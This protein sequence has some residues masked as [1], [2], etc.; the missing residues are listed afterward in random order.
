MTD[1]KKATLHKC[2]ALSSLGSVELRSATS[3]NMKCSHLHAQLVRL[4]KPN[5]ADI[6]NAHFR[7][8]LKSIVQRLE[9]N[10]IVTL[11]Q[12]RCMRNRDVLSLKL[13]MGQRLLLKSLIRNSKQKPARCNSIGQ[14][15]SIFPICSFVCK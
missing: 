2:E 4:I 11:H 9:Q 7:A 5:V 10:G 12:V 13:N 6:D 3:E 8:E 1:E 15:P 14:L